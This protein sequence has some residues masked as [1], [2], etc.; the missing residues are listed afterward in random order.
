MQADK[1]RVL[2]YRDH[3]LFLGLQQLRHR[4]NDAQLR[5]ILKGIYSNDE[6]DS[7]SLATTDKFSNFHDGTLSVSLPVSVTKNITVTPLITY[8]FPLS[9]DAKYE[10]RARGL[11]GAAVPSDRDNSHL[12]GGV[13]L[14]FTF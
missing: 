8:V 1:A 11:Q 3:S 7:N 5:K 6:F 12:Y 4:L 10:M 13:A 2:S 9:D 14:S